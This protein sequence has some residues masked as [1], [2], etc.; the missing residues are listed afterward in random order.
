[1]F[2]GASL[3]QFDRFG[4][5]GPVHGEQLGD[6]DSLVGLALYVVLVEDFLLSEVRFLV[7][8]LV[9][10]WLRA[11][12]PDHRLLLQFVQLVAYLAA[13]HLVAQGRTEHLL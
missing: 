12:P 13:A 8:L 6:V 3:P 7:V 10:N 4:Q 11:F 2:E 9:G 5:R 1:M